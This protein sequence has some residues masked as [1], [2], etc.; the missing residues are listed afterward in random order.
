MYSS[1]QTTDRA[2]P[3]G[4]EDKQLAVVV[5]AN[6]LDLPAATFKEGL[7]RRKQNRAALMDWVRSALVDGTDFGKIHVVSRS[8]CLAGNQC[9]NPA[10]FSKPSLFK[11]GAEKICGMLGVTVRYPTLPDYEKAA[12][13]GAN[14]SQIIIRCEI[15]DASG[16]VVADGVG[17]RVIAQDNGD[18]NKALKMAEKSAHIDA[19][20]RMAGLS[21]VFTQDIEDMIQR[22]EA[23][24]IQQ[25]DAELNTGFEGITKA[26]HQRLEARIRELGLDRTRV[27]DWMIKASRNRF[28]NFL[29]LNQ[30]F[31]Q[32]LYSKLDQFAGVSQ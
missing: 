22:R 3:A 17:A 7:D 14:L 15:L 18:I 11:P 23:E 19:T 12:L 20:L 27:K 24:S 2:K 30:D 21:E 6:P 10:H 13:S 26:Q 28:T 8:K 1:S 31:Y 4:N 32:H 29:E 25:A 16:R 5:A 9:K